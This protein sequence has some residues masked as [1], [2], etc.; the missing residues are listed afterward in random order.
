MQVEQRNVT[1]NTTE[2]GRSA[3]FLPESQMATSSLRLTGMHARVSSA[4]Q[5]FD[6][7]GKH[8]PELDEHACRLEHGHRDLGN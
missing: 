7:A 4:S 8:V 5:S 6:C 3:S 1:V 2:L